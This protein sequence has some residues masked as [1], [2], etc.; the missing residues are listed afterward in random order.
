MPE[1]IEA[2]VYDGL[3]QEYMD[4][5]EAK[6]LDIFPSPVEAI[7]WAMDQVESALRAVAAGR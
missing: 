6:L 1:K 5:M 3:S 4:R 7:R 2:A